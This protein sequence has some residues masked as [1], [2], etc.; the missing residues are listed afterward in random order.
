MK[1]PMKSPVLAALVLGLALV[2]C[3]AI[4]VYGGVTIKHTGYIRT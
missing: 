1:E 2:A 3:T 4:V